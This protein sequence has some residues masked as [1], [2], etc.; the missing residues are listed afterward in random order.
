MTFLRIP[1]AILYVACWGYSG[2]ATFRIGH[3]RLFRIGSIFSILSIIGAS[4][5]PSERAATRA[6]GAA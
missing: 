5:A 4:V 1:L 2:L 6:A 3:Y